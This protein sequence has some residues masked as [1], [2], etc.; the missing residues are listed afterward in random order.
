MLVHECEEKGD[1]GREQKD[2]DE[3]ILE[4]LPDQLQEGLPLLLVQLILSEL[5]LL[6]L[7]LIHGESLF[8]RDAKMLQHLIYR[9]RMGDF[10]GLHIG[11]LFE[12]R[13]KIKARSLTMLE[14][15]GAKG[16]ALIFVLPS[17]TVFAW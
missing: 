9:L 11:K 17:S 14:S 4:L 13:T 3:E 16:G 10:N 7:H 1:H 12:G 5:L 6:L 8:L 2:T 15:S